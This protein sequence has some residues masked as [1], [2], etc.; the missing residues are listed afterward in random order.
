MKPLEAHEI[1]GTWGTTLLPIL[2]DDAIDFPRLLEQVT[3][4]AASGISGIYTNGTAGEFYAQS[5]T[6]FDAINELVAGICEDKQIPFQIG[7][8]HMGA[9]LSLERMKRAARLKPAAI[10]VILP[11]WYPLTDDEAIDYLQRM[12]EAAD[13]I[14]LVLYNPPHAKRGL[15][16]ETYGKLKD[17]VPQLIGVKTAGG[18]AKWYEEMREHM[19]GLSV[20]VPGHRLASGIAE[21][22][23]GSYS[24][25]ACLNPAGAV[26]WF[27][28]MTSDPKGA[29]AEEKRIV[30]FIEQHIVPFITEQGYSNAA[31]DKLLTEIGGWADVGTRLRWP[32]RSILRSEAERL[33]PI[34]A[35]IMPELFED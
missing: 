9:Q 11:D 10:Q 23:N 4:L 13:G 5:E 2:E 8:S 30:A 3:K 33:R 14:G 31:V 32:Y 26:R 15:A 17:A 19:R 12:A 34:A 29:A 1:K 27:D 20:F 7:A 16:P 6:E 28:R 24:N 22:A 21:G 18:D 35:S 25:I